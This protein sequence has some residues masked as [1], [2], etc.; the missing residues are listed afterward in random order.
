MLEYVVRKVALVDTRGT[1]LVQSAQLVVYENDVVIPARSML[2]AK[3]LFE[4]F[5]SAVNE[6]GLGVNESTSKYMTQTRKAAADMQKFVIG[7]HNFE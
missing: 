4:Q 3:E 1:L 5:K 7:G 6:V 2:R